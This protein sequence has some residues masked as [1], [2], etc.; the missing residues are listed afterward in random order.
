[1]IIINNDNPCRSLVLTDSISRWADRYVLVNTGLMCVDALICTSHK[2]IEILGYKDE[3]LS[4]FSDN[5]EIL[6]YLRYKDE[7]LG[8]MDEIPCYLSYY[9]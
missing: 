8:Y 2:W 7:I 5:L 4:V 6:C 1:M 3:K 9:E